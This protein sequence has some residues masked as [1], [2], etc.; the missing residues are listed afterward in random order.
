MVS[1]YRV[2]KYLQGA[3]RRKTKVLLRCAS[4]ADRNT[5]RERNRERYIYINICTMKICTRKLVHF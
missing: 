4:E 3:L 2:K 1:K 5:A